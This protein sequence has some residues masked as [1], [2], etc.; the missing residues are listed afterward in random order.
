MDRAARAVDRLARATVGIEDHADVAAGVN[1][2]LG[3]VLGLISIFSGDTLNCGTMRIVRRHAATKHVIGMASLFL[4]VDG[5]LP[6]RPLLDVLGVTLA[7]YTGHILLARMTP[8]TG[9]AAYALVYALVV[10][11]SFQARHPAWERLRRARQWGVVALAP[12]I[13]LGVL[14]YARRQYRD[15]RGTWSTAAFLFGTSGCAED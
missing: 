9:I 15:H 6:D 5:T 12:L 4:A 14:L 1:L 2:T 10:A 13:T 11:E 7:V 3:H 8:A